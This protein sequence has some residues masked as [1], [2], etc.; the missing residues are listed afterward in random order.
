MKFSRCRVCSFLS[1]TFSS[2]SPLGMCHT[3]FL[4]IC[5]YA[6][7]PSWVDGSMSARKAPLLEAATVGLS[8]KLLMDGWESWMT[9]S[10]LILAFCC[11]MEVKLVVLATLAVRLR[12]IRRK[13]VAFWGGHGWPH[14]GGNVCPCPR[15]PDLDGK[16][17]NRALRSIFMSLIQNVGN[18]QMI[19]QD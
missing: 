14:R 3:L 8:L 15:R 12:D 2:Y 11:S 18:W 13:I 5:F 4:W 6:Y 16:K 10:W 7:L 17:W 19:M 9:D 1:I